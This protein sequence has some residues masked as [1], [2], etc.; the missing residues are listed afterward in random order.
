[1]YI[2]SF[3]RLEE[4]WGLRMKGRWPVLLGIHFVRVA[5][6]QQHPNTATMTLFTICDDKN[7]DFRTFNTMIVRCTQI[8]V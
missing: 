7:V 5:V 2:Y 6:A 1:M 4:C 3:G 8:V